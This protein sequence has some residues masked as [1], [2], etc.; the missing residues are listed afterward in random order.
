M[1]KAWAPVQEVVPVEASCLL[2]QLCRQ[3][4]IPCAGSSCLC[5]HWSPLSSAARVPPG[6]QPGTVV[7]LVIRIRL[8]DLG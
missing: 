4:A 8:I 6:L 7:V 3:T 5:P 2:P 1:P